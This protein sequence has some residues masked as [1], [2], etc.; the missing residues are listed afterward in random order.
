MPFVTSPISAVNRLLYQLSYRK[1]RSYANVKLSETEPGALVFPAQGNACGQVTPLFTRAW[2]PKTMIEKP[3]QKEA[4]K[5]DISKMDFVC[6]PKLGAALCGVGFS[7]YIPMVC[8]SCS[9]NEFASIA[10]RVTIKTPE[11]DPGVWSLYSVTDV[12]LP[13]YYEREPDPTAWLASLEGPK[14]AHYV[15]GYLDEA[16]I[17]KLGSHELFVKRENMIKTHVSFPELNNLRPRSIQTSTPA[18]N[19]FAG[20]DVTTYASTLAEHGDE[21]TRFPNYA[22]IYDSAPD[23]IGRMMSEKA[24]EL[25]PCLFVTLDANTMDA[26]VVQEFLD[27]NRRDYAASGFDSMALAAIDENRTLYGRSRSGIRYESHDGIATGVQWTT[28]SHSKTF[29]SMTSTFK[30]VH[31]PLLGWFYFDKSDDGW[32]LISLVK[33]RAPALALLSEL[34]AHFLRHGF[35][36]S[37]QVSESP[38]GSEFLSLRPHPHIT[39][40]ILVPK[41]GRMMSKL[42]WSAYPMDV[43]DHYS[44][45]RTV[46]IGLRQYVGCPILG[47]L[48][49]R[50]LFLTTDALYDPRVDAR[51]YK[52]L[53]YTQ[54]PGFDRPTMLAQYCDLYDTT[55]EEIEQLEKVF[56]SITALPFMV[57]N[58]LMN[59][60][61]GID[62]GFQNNPLD[63]LREEPV[64]FDSATVGPAVPSTRFVPNLPFWLFVNTFVEELFLCVVQSGF[65]WVGCFEALVYRSPRNLIV[66]C[67]MAAIR[68]VSPVGALLFHLGYNFA[69]L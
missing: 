10:Q 1:Y 38:F 50:V 18:S 32:L 66:H 48:L 5:I 39:T 53:L 45:S 54:D 17:K 20:P 25:G 67:F 15:R 33:G 24:E 11:P 42:F 59:K 52:Q 4:S 14:R 22:L 7:G 8:N 3:A 46:A 56:S 47:P 65:L 23:V 58:N 35:K 6:K 61:I 2:C 27:I 55:I 36:M 21:V 28:A 19:Y 51:K 34:R 9:H 37:C 68:K 30:P 12:R 26:S 16:P 29:C 63:L 60:I 43:I 44:Y 31:D 69:V 13:T 57:S 41:L 49:T 40:F 64:K 62:L